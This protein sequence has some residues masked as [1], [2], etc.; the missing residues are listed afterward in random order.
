MVTTSTRKATVWAATAALTALLVLPAA[1]LAQDESARVRVLHGSGDAPAVDVYAGKDAVVEGLEF[2]SITDYLTVPAGEYRIRVVPAG[3]TLKE[4]PVVIDAELTFEGGTATTVAATG[5][6]E[7][8]IIPQVLLDDPSP[9]VDMAQAR[10][11]HF[12]YD[13]PA[14]DIAPV[15]GDPII[16]ELAYPDDSGYADLPPGTYELEVRAAGSPDA[17]VT[18]PPLE[19]AAGTSSSAFAVGSLEAGT[20]TV[21]PALDASIPTTAQLR[22]LHGSPDAPAVDLVVNGVRVFGNL[23][24]GANSPYLTVPV[25][26]NQI[27]VVPAGASVTEGPFVIDATLPFE[28]D[29]RTTVVASNFLDDIEAN[30]I[31]DRTRVKAKKAQIRVGH[32][33]ADAPNVDIAADGSAAKDAILKDVPYKTVSDYIA[34]APGELDLDVREPGKKAVIADLPALPLEK[35]TNYSAYAIGSPADGSFQVVLLVDAEAE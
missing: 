26:E 1:A 30:V 21:V 11:V 24:F 23:P 22:V 12:A 28:G 7:E 4:G 15:G 35:G 17:V 33:S 3:A 9:S 32:F 13:A 19:F 16:T 5:S 29:T 34:V 20:F 10:V 8:G 6:L 31:P 27:Q 25:G 14:V 2:G 18:L